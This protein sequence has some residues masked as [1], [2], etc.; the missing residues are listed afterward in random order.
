MSRRATHYSPALTP[1]LYVTAGIVAI[2]A[3]HAGHTLVAVVCWLPLMYIGHMMLLTFHEAVHY[4]LSTKRWANEARGV[5]IGIFAFVPLSVF[6]HVHQLHHAR[7]ASEEDAELWPYS[8]PSVPRWLRIVAAVTELTLSWP[9]AQLQFLRG[10][11]A[12]GRLTKAVRGRIAL[13]YAVLAIVWTV[14]IAMIAE[15]GWWEEFAIGYAVPML[16]A[17]NIHAWRKFV[18]HMGLQSNSPTTAAR[19]IAPERPGGRVVSALLLHI[20][21]HSTHHRNGNLHFHEL[22][23]ATPRVHAADPNALPVFPS[24]RAALLDMLPTL[25]DPRVGRQWQSSRH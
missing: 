11:F 20:N 18:E 21:Y 1:V 4:H 8:R 17:F 12:T 23:E 15:Y 9:F 6:R 2:Q 10:T 22:A 24:Y 19:C 5:I 3:W 7:L 25:A 16:G 13:E 14:A